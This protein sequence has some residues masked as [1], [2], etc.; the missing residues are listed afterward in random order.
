MKFEELKDLTLE[1]IKNDIEMYGCGEKSIILSTSY[2]NLMLND[3]LTVVYGWYDK[4][5]DSIAHNSYAPLTDIEEKQA[6][7]IAM[8]SAEEVKFLI[9]YFFKTY[10]KGGKGVA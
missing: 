3:K 8:Q 5:W 6:E 10:Y 4:Q 2:E 9:D 7:K 1:D